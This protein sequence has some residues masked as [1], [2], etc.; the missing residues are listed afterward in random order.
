M[1]SLANVTEAGDLVL[2]AIV[3]AITMA[4]GLALLGIDAA[5]GYIDS[6]RH[7]QPH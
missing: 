4:I 6:R 5:V 2:L 3:L 7:R 1:A